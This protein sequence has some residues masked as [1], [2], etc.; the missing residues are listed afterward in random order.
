[1]GERTFI[2]RKRDKDESRYTWQADDWGP[3]KYQ[4]EDGEELYYVPSTTDYSGQ[5]RGVDQFGNIF[6]VEFSP[7][8]EYPIGEYRHNY[9][10]FESD[11]DGIY[12]DWAGNT[13]MATWS[14][15]YDPNSTVLN[16]A[17]VHP[18]T[19]TLVLATYAPF[20]DSDF[21][22]TGHSELELIPDYHDGPRGYVSMDMDDKGYN[23]FT[24][25]CAD[26]TRMVMEEIFGKQMNPWLFTTP[27]DSRDF[28]LENG[29]RYD[30]YGNV[31]IKLTEDQMIRASNFIK[32]LRRQWRGETRDI[33]D[34]ETYE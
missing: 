7:G 5:S 18:K 24:N 32:G 25:N 15:L 17:V 34:Y 30:D 29:G 28:L 33:E 22:W 27:R 19:G 9:R 2:R 4:T 14:D 10:L 8:W 26:A 23:L 16:E 20:Q 1:M 13:Q 6:N 3:W 12:K 31:Y 21:Y 11:E